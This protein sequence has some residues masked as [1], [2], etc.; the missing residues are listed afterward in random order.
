MKTYSG[1]HILK[2]HSIQNT[3]RAYVGRPTCFTV[4]FS[5]KLLMFFF[6][7]YV[8]YLLRLKPGANPEHSLPELSLIFKKALSKIF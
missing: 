4:N 5:A 7:N 3:P 2:Y 6:F 1:H 8:T